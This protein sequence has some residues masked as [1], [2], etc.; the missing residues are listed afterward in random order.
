MGFR[1]FCRVIDVELPATDR[2][3]A[4]DFLREEAATVTETLH[5]WLSELI[6]AWEI[7]VPVGGFPRAAENYTAMARL[8]RRSSRPSG[9]SSTARRS[10]AFSSQQDRRKLCSR[11]S[12]RA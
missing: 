12:R 7:Y 8:G 3:R 5:P 2:I 1:D 4:K 10:G 11:G 6:D 9:T